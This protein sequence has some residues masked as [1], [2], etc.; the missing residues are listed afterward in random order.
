MGSRIVN[1]TKFH[2]LLKKREDDSECINEIKIFSPVRVFRI[3]Y[4]SIMMK[5]KIPLQTEELD[6]PHTHLLPK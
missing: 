4:A 3:K 2:Q 6:G 1:N 5:Q